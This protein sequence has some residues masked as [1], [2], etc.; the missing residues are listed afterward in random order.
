MN[1][2]SS[3]HMM[4]GLQSSILIPFE[5]IKGPRVGPPMH[6]SPIVSSVAVKAPS[7]EVI[8]TIGVHGESFISITWRLCIDERSEIYCHM[9]SGWLIQSVDRSR[10]ILRAN[11]SLTS[12]WRGTG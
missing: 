9:P 10:M 3:D 6:T 1:L 5:I 2:E 8:L 11:I 7:G 4:D 12:L